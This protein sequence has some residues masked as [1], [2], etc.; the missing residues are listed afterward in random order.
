MSAD[1]LLYIALKTGPL[2]LIVGGFALALA[3]LVGFAAKLASLGSDG[4]KVFSQTLAVAATFGALAVTTGFLMAASR[5]SAVA[6]VIPAVLTLVGGLALF[7]IDKDF[8]KIW[9]VGP[10]IVSFSLMMFVGA[11]LGSIERQDGEMRLIPPE[12]LLY[13]ARLEK[14]VNVFRK[15]HGL[16]PIG[17]AEIRNF[18]SD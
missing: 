13:E 17:I 15:A 10:A 5:E 14:A 11:A 7:A 12:R 4:L 18:R 8:A 2:L 16:P 3:A 1:H 6:D 9:V